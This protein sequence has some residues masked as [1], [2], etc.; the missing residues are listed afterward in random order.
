MRQLSEFLAPKNW[1]PKTET[2]EANLPTKPKLENQEKA[3]AID[4][5]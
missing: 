5:T 4:F 1:S 2:T 3:Q